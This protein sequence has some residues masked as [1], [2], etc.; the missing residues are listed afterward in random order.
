MDVWIGATTAGATGI[1]RWVSG[2]PLQWADWDDAYPPISGYIYH[3]TTGFRT[4][5]TQ[6]VIKQYLC[7]KPSVCKY[8]LKLEFAY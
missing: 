4:Y 8:S 7:E 3:T 1:Y 5:Y 2:Y 6:G